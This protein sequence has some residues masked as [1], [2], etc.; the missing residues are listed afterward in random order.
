MN[1]K[2]FRQ[3]LQEVDLPKVFEILFQK[4]K[5]IENP[6]VDA[7][8]TE[9]MY[10]PVI[11]TLMS[12]PPQTPGWLIRVYWTEPSVFPD[13]PSLNEPSY[14]DVV[15]VN[16]NYEA[17]PEGAKPWGGDYKVKDDAPE[18][19][20]NCNWENYSQYFGLGLTNWNEMIDSSVEKPD[21]DSW[22][23]AIA[24]ILWEMTFYGWTSERIEEFRE[25][26]NDSRREYL[27]AKENGTL[28]TVDLDELTDTD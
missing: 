11:D 6:P 16:P 4:D 8:E 10:R 15:F 9:Q 23:E 24:V 1:N 13:D 28:E 17:P 3:L 18:G 2:T 7:A 5:N 26:L 27:E 25:E 12:Y 21:N 22:E 14:L 19:Y 20:Y